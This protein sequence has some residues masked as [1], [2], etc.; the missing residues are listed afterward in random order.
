MVMCDKDMLYRNVLMSNSATL[1]FKPKVN[2]SLSQA[3]SAVFC[4]G[5][6]FV[7]FFLL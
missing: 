6:F 7:C 4:C 5:L 3:F 1:G 2:S